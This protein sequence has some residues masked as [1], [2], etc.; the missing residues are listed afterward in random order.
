[1]LHK[2]TTNTLSQGSHMFENDR[3]R[4]IDF[5]ILIYMSRKP[6]DHSRLVEADLL[7]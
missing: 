5:E 2:H 4:N 6:R 3:F 1:M 7:R